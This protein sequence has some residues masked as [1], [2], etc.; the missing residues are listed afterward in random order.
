MAD[1][2]NAPAEKP[3]KYSIFFTDA[4]W[5][6]VFGYVRSH[7]QV[8]F[9]DKELRRAVA[10]KRAEVFKLGEEWTG[11]RSNMIDLTVGY[12]KRH[13][14]NILESHVVRLLR[15][16]S[17]IDPVYDRAASL[18]VLSVGPRNENEVFHLIAHGFRPQNIEAIDVVSNSPLV[19]VADMHDI[20]FPDS[21]FDVVVSGWT[22]PYSR[23]AKLAIREKVRVLRTGGLLCLGL[24]R[25]GPDHLEY[26]NLVRQGSSIYLS[27]DQ[28]LADIG[29]AVEAVPFRHDPLDPLKKGAI[30][31]IARIR[32]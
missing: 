8:M 6:K 13:M 18:K 12:N 31:V 14:Q 16:L 4:E 21:S 11:D 9:F 24:T 32:K 7:P 17:I 19:R 15:P 27:S 2:N 30:L 26:P 29:S 28:I 22:L 20:P 1:S 5:Q 25:V 23:N 10:A 3:S